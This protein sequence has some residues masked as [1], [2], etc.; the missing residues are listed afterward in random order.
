M[1]NHKLLSPSDPHPLTFYLTYILTVYLAFYLR[2]Y[3]T[4]FLTVYLAFFLTSYLT[5]ILH[6]F[7]QS[8]WLSILIFYVTSCTHNWGPAVPTWIWLSQ[9]KPGSAHWVSSGARRWRSRLRSG[10]AHWDL[11]LA[12]EVWQFQLRSGACGWGLEVPT[13]IWSSRL[14]CGSAHWGLAVPCPLRAVEVRQCSQLAPG[15][16]GRWRRAASLI[17]SRQPHLAGWEKAQHGSKF[18]IDLHLAIAW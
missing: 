15:G 1:F 12:V 5:F 7:W 10:S 2:F 11:E 6:I 13:E 3:L 4:C 18:K 14:R 8:I 16:G 17:K 9:L